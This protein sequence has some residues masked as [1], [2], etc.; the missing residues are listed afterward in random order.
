MKYQPAFTKVPLPDLA[1]EAQYRLSF[2]R[3]LEPLLKSIQALGQTTPILCRQ[4]QNGLELF[5]GF[6]RRDALRRLRKK[7]ALALVFDA[8]EMDEVRAFRIAFFENAL[9]RGLNPAEQ[10]KAAQRLKELGVSDLE[11]AR[12]FF[13]AAGLGVG[14]KTI[15]LL[16]NFFELDRQWKRYLTEKDLS[17]KHLAW[18]LRLPREDQATLKSL[19]KLRPTA[20]QLRQA[21]EMIEETWKRDRISLGRLMKII[22]APEFEQL[23]QKLRQL[24]YPEFERLCDRHR[25]ILARMNISGAVKIEPLDYFEQPGYRLEL[26][27][28]AQTDAAKIFEQLL[29]AAAGPDWKKLFDLDD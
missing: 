5:S 8:K 11:I 17:L 29:S 4:T 26:L 19:L 13:S 12:S 23:L 28:S 6:Q 15:G 7:T 9:T 18:F 10:A 21:L 16:R 1:G 20:S 2:F 22:A 27:L 24:R 25:K 14:V 3:P